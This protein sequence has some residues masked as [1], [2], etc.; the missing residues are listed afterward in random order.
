M[1]FAAEDPWFTRYRFARLNDWS[2]ISSLEWLMPRLVFL[3]VFAMAARA[4]IDTDF[5]WHL[6]AGE[7]TWLTHRPV[8]VDHIS[9]TR[10]GEPWINHSWLGQVLIYLVY[11]LAGNF[12]VAGFVAVIA[13]A[14]MT[15][16][17]CQMQGHPIMRGFI[18][19]LAGAAAAPVWSARPQI[20]SLVLLAALAYFY[21]QDR[22]LGKDRLWVSI[23]LFILWSNLHGG[24]VIGIIFLVLA[25]AGE[26][27]NKI[28]N[29][30]ENPE[31]PWRRILKSGMWVVAGW[32]VVIIN[33]NGLEA[34]AIPFKT[35]NI[36]LLR[37]SI[38]EWGSPDFHEGALQPFIWLLMGILGAVGFSRRKMD[39]GDYLILVGFCYLALLAKR[40]IAPF[41]IVAAPILTHYL[42]ELDLRLPIKHSIVISRPAAAVGKG[43]VANGRYQPRVSRVLNLGILL[44]VLAAGVTKLFA[45]TDEKLIDHFASEVFPV[46]AVAWIRTN[47]PEGQLFNSYNWGGYLSWELRQYS[48]FVDGRTDLYGEEFLKMYSDISNGEMDWE[49]NLMDF[50]VNLVLIETHSGLS[51]ELER[52][53]NWIKQYEDG[54]AVIYTRQEG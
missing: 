21:Y 51:R 28:A 39:W 27:L 41:A 20:F 34:W 43:R 47:Q 1:R 45:V 23:P 49:K 13:A 32:A 16:V 52:S 44:L 4:P 38:D 48:V 29:Y 33:P 54:I 42:A 18:V 12:G 19:V 10:Y 9:F 26:G 36:G 2:N 3:L 7:E 30:R 37:E 31:M 17:Y 25:F 6:R 11:T 24:Y 50:S 14:S 22:W 5:W 53:S 35:I 8:L 46:G 15:L 40:N